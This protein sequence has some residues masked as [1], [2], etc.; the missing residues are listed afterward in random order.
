MNDHSPSEIWSYF[1]SQNNN[2]SSEVL[3]LAFV[4]LNLVEPIING[5]PKTIFLVEAFMS[6]TLA[7]NMV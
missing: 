3:D 5:L 6:L 4:I 1:Q 7:F 2:L